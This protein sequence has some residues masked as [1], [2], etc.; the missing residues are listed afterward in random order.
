MIPATAYHLAL[1]LETAAERTMAKAPTL[2]RRG[3]PIGGDFKT[4]EEGR[5]KLKPKPKG[6]KLSPHA[7][8]A[9]KNKRRWKPAK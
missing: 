2:V 1:A 9:S 5:T 6:A 7:Q 8:Y 3:I 4:I